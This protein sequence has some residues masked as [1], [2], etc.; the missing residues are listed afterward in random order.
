MLM[1][2]L[3]FFERC[4]NKLVRNTCWYK[5]T[6][7][8]GA[9]K[10]WD[11][12]TFGLKII[13]LGSGAAEHDFDYTGLPFAASNWALG[14]QSLVHDFAILKNYYSYISDGGYVIITICPF[15]GLF[16]M[17]DK[18]HNF[19][20]YTFLHPATI[21]NFD[22]LERIEA[23]KYKMN[24]SYYHLL[25]CVTSIPKE[26]TYRIKELVRSSRCGNFAE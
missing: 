15:S 3:M 6:I 22:E 17:Y 19:K 1:R 8:G 9:T 4:L 5:T 2:L 20:Y 26:L 21:D 12:N 24:P 16:S 18:K 14:P 7:F 13:N 23:L 10:F 11:L 25:Q